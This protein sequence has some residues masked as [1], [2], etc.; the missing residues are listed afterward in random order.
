[1]PDDPASASG[2]NVPAAPLP[3]DAVA[4]RVRVMLPLPLP[5]PLDYCVPTCMTPSPG[6]FVAVELGPRRLFGVVW[7][8]APE[9]GESLPAA[10][11]KPLCEVLPSP[12]LSAELR[13]F[14]ARVADYTLAPPGVVL[15]MA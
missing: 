13:R 15:R 1:M 8:D 3:R 9:A 7:D 14:V 4:Q 12:P 10:R 6:S 11:L 2:V 5:E